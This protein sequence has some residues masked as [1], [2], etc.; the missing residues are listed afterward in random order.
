MWEECQERRR[1][2]GKK[3]EGRG[4]RGGG[5]EGSIGGGRGKRRNGSGSVEG[6]R[7]VERVSIWRRRGRKGKVSGG[8]VMNRRGEC[9]WRRREEEKGVAAEE[10][11]M[12][13][14]QA[15]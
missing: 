5:G 1:E 2:E 8:A 11:G 4:E 3:G 7:E 10:R 9:S 12:S 13:S 6:G 14:A 15:V